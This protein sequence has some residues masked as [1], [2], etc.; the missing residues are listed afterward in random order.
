LKLFG[1]KGVILKK[2][3]EGKQPTTFSRPEDEDA[4]EFYGQ[5]LARFLRR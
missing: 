5:Q 1:E 2:A 3:K 4:R